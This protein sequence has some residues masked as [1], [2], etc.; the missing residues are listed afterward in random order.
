MSPVTALRR[1]WRFVRLVHGRPQPRT[2][3][4]N[5]EQDRMRQAIAA[6]R[7]ALSQQTPAQRVLAGPHYGDI[8]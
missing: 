6:R 3:Q 2:L 1:W 8:H 7:A 5:P 4:H